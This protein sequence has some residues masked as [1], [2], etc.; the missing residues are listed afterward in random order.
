MRDIITSR[1]PGKKHPILPT[2]WPWAGS[3]EQRSLEIMQEKNKK[4][5]IFLCPFEL[6][7]GLYHTQKLVRKRSTT[8]THMCSLHTA[9]YASKTIQ[10]CAWWKSTTDIP[11]E[12]IGTRQIQ[13]SSKRTLQNPSKSSWLFTYMMIAIYSSTSSTSTCIAGCKLKPQ[14]SLFTLHQPL[15]KVIS[16]VCLKDSIP[17]YTNISC[18]A[19]LQ[20]PFSTKCWSHLMALKV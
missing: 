8:S 20:W 7:V 15:L 19:L 17:Y 13:R 4:L 3:A 2:A 11:L 9:F 16:Q 14:S 5:A 10:S 6:L 12:W 18:V 1:S